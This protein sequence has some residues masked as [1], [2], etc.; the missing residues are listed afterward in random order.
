MNNFYWQQYINEG[1]GI[2]LLPSATCTVVHPLCACR[3]IRASQL[4]L[5]QS[6]QQVSFGPSTKTLFDEQGIGDADPGWTG[7]MPTL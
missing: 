7:P 6:S 1:M 4:Q 3:R 5:P 2:D